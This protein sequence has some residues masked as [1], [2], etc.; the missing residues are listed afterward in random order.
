MP[1]II[2]VA[3]SRTGLHMWASQEQRL[4]VTFDTCESRLV[5]AAEMDAQG[6]EM[7]PKGLP[8]F[9]M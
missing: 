5:L 8:C 9:R 2:H 3:D 4:G 7:N 6:R 1:P